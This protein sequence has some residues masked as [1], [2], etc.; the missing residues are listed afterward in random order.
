MQIID[1]S[2]YHMTEYFINLMVLFNDYR[3]ARVAQSQN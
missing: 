1:F 3:V 2:L